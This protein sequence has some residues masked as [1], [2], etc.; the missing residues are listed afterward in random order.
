MESAGSLERHQRKICSGP[1][2]GLRRRRAHERTPAIARCNAL[3]G[4]AWHPEREF[5]VC[6]CH[7]RKKNRK[8]FALTREKQK[9]TP[10][11][12]KTPP[13]NNKNTKKHQKNT[14]FVFR[15]DARQKTLASKKTIS[16]PTKNGMKQ[17]KSRSGGTRL[18]PDDGSSGSRPQR[19]RRSGKYRY[20]G[21]L[22]SRRNCCPSP[23][24]GKAAQPRSSEKNAAS[25]AGQ[26]PCARWAVGILLY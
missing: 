23:R 19:R 13:K 1:A 11:S 16:H 3:K 22:P 2:N 7:R 15:A 26:T 6:S 20:L 18:T 10:K 4:Y 8:K 9:K 24:A 12:T 25:R 14:K 5:P 17:K 21:S